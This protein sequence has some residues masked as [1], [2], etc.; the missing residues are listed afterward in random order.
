M[1]EKETSFEGWAILE[2][3]GHRRLAGYVTETEIAGAGVL[4]LDVPG[5]EEDAEPFATQFYAPSALYCLTPTTEEIVRA[6][7]ARTRPAPV[8]RWELPSAPKRPEPEYEDLDEDPWF[9][10]TDADDDPR[11]PE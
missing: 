11:R 2:L 7:A 8:Q 6:V 10:G 1:T 4:R 9:G 3:M 5:A